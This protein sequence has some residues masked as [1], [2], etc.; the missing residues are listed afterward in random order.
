LAKLSSVELKKLEAEIDTKS[1]M[2]LKILEE[3][4]S[5]EK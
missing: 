4:A 2:F 1:K 5:E 3:S